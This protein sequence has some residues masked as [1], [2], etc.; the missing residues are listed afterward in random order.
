MRP[1]A[2]APPPTI[3]GESTTLRRSLL[4]GGMITFW[5]VVA[6]AR[7]YYLQV[8]QYVHF[9]SRAQR[10]QQRTVELAP[11]RGEIFDRQMRP[12]A[13]SIAVD[14]VFAVPT[15]IPDR[16]TVARLL[17]P[18]LGLDVVELE[19]HLNAFHSFCWVKRKASV[20]EAGRVREL[21]LKGIY[22]QKEMKRFYPK[23]DLAGGVLGYVG[24]DD[25]GLAGLE[26]GLNDEIRG[27]PGKIL[28]AE[29]ARRHSFRSVE[30]AGTPGKNLI[31]T[32]DETIQYIAEKALAAAVLKWHAAG[33]VVIVQDPNTGEI[34]AMANA[35]ALS[36]NSFD[37]NRPEDRVNRAVS[38]VY[39]P[40]S[41]FKL[42]TVSAALEEGLTYPAEVIDCQ[43]GSITL[44]GHVI[45][46]WKRFGALTAQQVLIH[47][48][49]VGSIKLGLRLGA[50]RL[51]HY[52]RVYGFGNRT[53]IELPGEER[54]LLKPPDHWSGIS[55]GEMS[56]GQEVGVTA[57]QLVSAY[58]AMANGGISA[59]D[60]ARR[61]PR[62]C[63]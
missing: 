35:P 4:L 29:D 18:V 45:H 37:N 31:L 52:M 36:P 57:L 17:G 9:L 12:L 27:R 46:D 39:E 50:D 21:N 19:G 30:R 42:V 54:G 32:L 3:R 47:S 40:G 58:S 10:Q 41:T 59:Q 28:L 55:I 48:S 51:Y 11:Q 60:H 26:Y 62:Q 13:M 23:D 24:M 7:L 34:L 38:W 5:M 49:D 63:A 53:E 44:A 61:V 33:G 16:R 20:E 43:M 1:H 56:I 8:I 25:D 14:S 6:V 2:P 15:E 22:F